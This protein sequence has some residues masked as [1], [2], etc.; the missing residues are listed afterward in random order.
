MDARDV[1]LLVVRWLHLI[2]AAAWVGGSVFYLVVLRP[3]ARRSPDSFRLVNAD[4]AAEFRG[5]VD[6]SIFVLLT[7][8]A[9]LTFDRLTGGVAGVPYVVA[10]AVKIALSVWMFLL[11]RA[12]RRKARAQHA[13]SPANV[14]GPGKLQKLARAVS[15]YNAIVVL[16]IIVFLLADLLKVLYEMALAQR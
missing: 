2:A 14:G 15:G 8:G 7:T 3:A 16:G 13:A 4:T 12:R 9:I 10:L 1:F 6:T 11:V 5:L